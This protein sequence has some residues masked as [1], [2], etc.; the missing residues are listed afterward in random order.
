LPQEGR[1]KVE[2]YIGSEHLTTNYRGIYYKYMK[3][4]KYQATK[5]E[6]KKKQARQLYKQ[7]L[8]LRQVGKIV[9]MSHQWVADALAGENSFDKV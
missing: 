5:K 1:S 2:G 8:T 6:Q 9:G 3:I 4:S 7:G